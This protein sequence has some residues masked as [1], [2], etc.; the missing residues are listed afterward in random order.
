MRRRRDDAPRPP[1][2]AAAR[3]TRN[4]ASRS[5]H[6]PSAHARALQA[7]AAEADPAEKD[8]KRKK[9]LKKMIDSYPSAAMRTRLAQISWQKQDSTELLS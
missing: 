5:L 1:A 7:S 8:K 6:I 9:N 3:G 4:S 2:K